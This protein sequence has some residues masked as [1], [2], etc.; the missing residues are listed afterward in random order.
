[1]NKPFYA[2]DGLDKYKLDKQ[3]KS[4]LQT[5][6]TVFFWTEHG[7]LFYRKQYNVTTFGVICFFVWNTYT[8]QL[9]QSV[10]KFKLQVELHFNGL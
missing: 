7:S 8:E 1:M 9:P 6:T 10:W 4:Y 3:T 5:N 2:L